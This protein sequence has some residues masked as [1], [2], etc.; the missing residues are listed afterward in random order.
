MKKEGFKRG[1]WALGTSEK[2]F[3]VISRHCLIVLVWGQSGHILPGPIPLYL[4]GF[5]GGKSHGEKKLEKVEF[6]K[7]LCR[8]LNKPL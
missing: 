4:G 2:A 8:R 3:S 5:L 1:V 7:N 6:S